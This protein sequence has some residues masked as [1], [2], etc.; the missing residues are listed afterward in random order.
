M[1]YF[2][3]HFVLSSKNSQGKC[4][5]TSTLAPA[6]PSRGRPFGGRS[7][8]KCVHCVFWHGRTLPDLCD[9]RNEPSKT[10][11]GVRIYL[12]QG[13]CWR[14]TGP[15]DRPT[16]VNPYRP[17]PF[18]PC[19]AMTNLPVGRGT[20]CTWVGHCPAC[21]SRRPYRRPGLFDRFQF[22]GGAGPP[23]PAPP[24]RV[25]RTSLKPGAA[26]GPCPF[27]PGLFPCRSQVE[28]R[29]RRRMLELRPP[30]QPSPAPP[31]FRTRG[32]WHRSSR[33]KAA[34]GVAL[35]TR[36]RAILSSTRRSTKP[37]VS[38]LTRTRHRGRGGP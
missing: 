5:P 18:L 26:C 37:T 36:L 34:A 2:S 6:F 9:A 15:A 32:R 4:K 25:S 27:V 35:L 23:V 31:R 17:V 13:Q 7:C 10:A 8:A 1:R 14:T 16:V 19:L 38:L 21:T 33:G 20:T 24:G 28:N 3:W 12:H 29:F 22:R 11:R 30:S